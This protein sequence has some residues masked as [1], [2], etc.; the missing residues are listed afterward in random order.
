M[1]A[2]YGFVR[3]EHSR[4]IRAGVDFSLYQQ[5]QASNT[6]VLRQ[7]LGLPP[8]S[9][10]VGVVAGFKPPKSLHH[11]VEVSRRVHQVQPTVKFLMI[12]DGELRSPLESK[13]RQW[14]LEGTVIITGWRS[15]VPDLLRLLDIF[16][17]TSQWEGAPLV[18][19]EACL[20]GVPIVSTNVDG[21]AEIVENG[22]NGFLVPAGDVDQMTQK[23]LWLLDNEDS[24]KEMGEKGR[25]MVDEFSAE[26]MVRDYESLYTQLLQGT[27]RMR[28]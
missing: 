5:E 22:E 27:P 12:G 17:L 2:S 19:V 7:E 1:G 16:L 10:I 14:S 8:S 26:K 11:F 15:D 21:I 6:H 23:I 3:K 28:S 9:K 20:A 4:T 25:S 18:L 13:I 24:R